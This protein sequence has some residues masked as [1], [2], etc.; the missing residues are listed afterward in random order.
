[1]AETNFSELLQKSLFLASKA[2]NAHK[3]YSLDNIPNLPRKASQVEEE[4]KKA[5]TRANLDG[6][7]PELDSGSIRLFSELNFDADSLGRDVRGLSTEEVVQA[8]SDALLR[9][10]L[11]SFIL[12]QH[13]NAVF[14]TLE[15]SKRIVQE[16][17]R[18]SLDASVQELWEKE[19]EKF[20]KQ[21]SKQSV[22]PSSLTGDVSLKTP[23]SRRKPYS[24]VPGATSVQVES[25]ERGLSSNNLTIEFASVIRNLIAN[26]SSES[27]PQQ[28]MLGSITAKMEVPPVSATSLSSFP[29]A[30]Q[31]AKVVSS[32]AHSLKYLV[33]IFDALAWIFGERSKEWESSQRSSFSN[34]REACFD[35]RDRNQVKQAVEGAI[36]SL[37]EKFRD[38]KVVASIRSHP[39]HALRGGRPGLIEDIRAYLRVLLHNDMSF[40]T[41]DTQLLHQLP[42]WPQIFLAFRCGDVAAACKIAEEANA[43]MIAKGLHFY[44]FIRE[45]VSTQDRCLSEESL[46]QLSQE[47]SLVARRSNDAYLRICYLLLAKC[48]PNYD[49][50]WELPSSDYQSVLNSIEDY[51]WFHLSLIRLDDKQLPL[52]L[53]A[54]RLDLVN[55]QQEIRDFGP[56]YFDPKGERPLFYTMILILSLQF[57]KAVEYLSKCDGFLLY[58]VHIAI[59]LYYYGALR[60]REELKDAIKSLKYIL[61]PFEVD[62][63]IWEYVQTIA[64][65]RVFDAACYIYVLRDASLRFEYLKELILYSSE[66]EAL[67]GYTSPEGSRRAGFLHQLEHMLPEQDRKDNISFELATVAAIEA[68][69]RGDIP[70]AIRLYDIAG[71]YDRVA[72]ILVR[73]LC[74]E[75]IHSRSSLS[76]SSRSWLLEESKR[77]LRLHSE[78]VSGTT[79]S[80]RWF[81]GLGLVVSLAEFVDMVRQQKYEEAWNEISNLGIFPKNEREVVTKSAEW[82]SVSE[83]VDQLILERLAPIIVLAMDCLVALHQ[84]TKTLQQQAERSASSPSSP[85][86]LFNKLKEYETQ[87]RNLITFA[88]LLGI[89]NPDV[90]AKLMTASL[91][92]S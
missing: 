30:C 45:F 34:K 89:Q 79:S 25:E 55:V 72:A 43:Q 74:A 57:A 53:Q 36:R 19:K 77:Y 60:T 33:F 80:S 83:E 40:I 15:D 92:L 58:C 63:L 14:S 70:A 2:E 26:R 41:P 66:Y 71:E 5:L 20:L 10:D 28:S 38:G 13:E 88:T 67:L 52:S 35:F 69:D 61:E 31:F 76:S 44:H 54:Y 16:D 49:E 51:L 82:K 42:L 1:M 64:K 86:V 48:N 85:T 62:K 91:A 29:L 7:S 75:L 90:S 6:G 24:W 12:E 50:K 59:I 3:K 47:Y 87:G 39:R 32:Q 37:E 56:S 23:A 27:V 8:P 11:D 9:N 84:R 78:K 17:I 18:R 21:L 46:L 22:V 65:T 73:R 68:N 4:A 81:S